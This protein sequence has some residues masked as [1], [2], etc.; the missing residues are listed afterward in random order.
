MTLWSFWTG[1]RWWFDV[2]NQ[3]VVTAV[4]AASLRDNVFTNIASA[5]LS[6]SRADLLEKPDYGSGIPT[7][8]GTRKTANQLSSPAPGG[9]GG[10]QRPIK[11]R[12]G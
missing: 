7:D 6:V 12:G 11:S 3:T 2:E 10:R 5:V 9:T 4:D 1:R 8:C